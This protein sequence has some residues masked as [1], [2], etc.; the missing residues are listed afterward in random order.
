MCR[1]FEY[2]LLVVIILIIGT[3]GA[4]KKASD[5]PI[6]TG[7][8]LGQKPPGKIPEI[9]APGVISTRYS[10]Q[11]IAFTPDGKE[12]FLWLG[13]NRPYCTI[14]WMKETDEGWSPLQ[15][16]PFSG[17][18]VDMKF[19]FSPDGRTFLFS[20]NRPH[21][22]SGNPTDNLDIWTME[23]S[24]S[25]WG[26]PKRFGLS[27]NGKS[28]DY[29]PSMAENG[30]LYFMSDREE[31]LGEDDIYY[32]GFEGGKLTKARNIGP[33]I[34][35]S[36]NEGDPFIAPDE[37]YI[38]F[39]SR[40]R[41]DG[42]GNND[43]FI[44]YRKN[45]GTWTTPKNL[46]SEINTVAEEVC[47]MVSHDGKYLFFSSNRKLND[48]FPVIPLTLDQIEK[49][50][51]NPGNGYYDIYW[52]EAGIIEEL[53]SKINRKTNSPSSSGY[54]I[55]TYES[56]F[57]KKHKKIGLEVSKNW[58]WPFEGFTEI[59]SHPNFDPET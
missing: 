30:N 35:T 59:Y 53:R 21:E 25:G 13:E 56:G 6:L 36:L 3:V 1:K 29:Y 24:P 12:L 9:F 54:V 49:A 50:L 44:S 4:Q 39:C 58:A 40:D 27:V 19:S 5:F 57:E 23:R 16:A 48:R 15:V 47:P 37:S 14:L 8:Y 7:P 34:N 31:G 55:K 2:L 45:D 11:Q 22:M 43:L 26:E 42:F 33:P 52:V 46:G 51:A 18:Y 20:S 10:E 17:K 28:H 41:K 38:L 32:A